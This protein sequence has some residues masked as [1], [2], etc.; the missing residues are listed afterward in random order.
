MTLKLKLS[1]IGRLVD[2]ELHVGQFTVLAGPNNTGKS[3][4]AK[5]LYSLFNSMN[6]NHAE[7]CLNSLIEPARS[8]LS[9]LTSLDKSSEEETP[10]TLLLHKLGQLRALVMESSMEDVDGLDD[11]ISALANRAEDMQ[12][13]FPDTIS[14]MRFAT[15]RGT[16][17]MPLSLRDDYLRQMKEYLDV[18][19]TALSSMDAK[20]FIVR[21]LEHAVKE[22]LLHNFQVPQLSYLSAAEDASSEIDIEGVGKFKFS[23]EGTSFNVDYDG[24]RRLQQYSKVIYLESPVYWKLKHALEDLRAY[25]IYPHSRRIQIGEV[26][27][28]FYDLVNALRYEY[29][30]DMAFS[31]LYERLTSKEVLG[32]KIRI[33][34]GGE[35]S[36]RE[37]G[38][39]FSLPVTATGVAN[40]GILALLIGRK[41]LDEES[42]LF[43]DEPEAHLHRRWQ[44]IMAEALFELAKGGV[45]VVVATHSTDILEWLE[46]QIKQNPRDEELV[47]LNEFPA[48]NGAGEAPDFNGKMAAIKQALA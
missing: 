19:R 26:P 14:Y 42:V 12:K 4:A 30:G 17:R 37:N 18:L 39:S 15:E 25:P 5:L 23:D 38:R 7:V 36:F 35:L 34:G 45:R 28:Y 24:L 43:V 32:G 27:R 10:L 29:I 2:A 3:Q 46:G 47:A 33:S 48:H 6:S 31:D 13:M 20:G 8:A 44:L 21:G 11:I 40:L 41:V 9:R 22:N 1:N 16:F